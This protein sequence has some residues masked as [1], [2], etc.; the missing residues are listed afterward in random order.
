MT[1][2]PL[3]IIVAESTEILRP[4]DH[5]GCAQAS[6][7]VT[8]SKSTSAGRETTARRRQHDAPDAVVRRVAR[9]RRWQALDHRVGSLSIGNSVAPLRGRRHEQRA[10]DDERFLVGEQDAL[11]ARAAASVAGSPAAPT[12]AASTQSASGSVA[13]SVRPSSRQRARRQASGR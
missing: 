5:V 1:S 12:I 3:F 2:S 4:I 10:T 7:G 13:T 8:R 9:V 6:S 11:A